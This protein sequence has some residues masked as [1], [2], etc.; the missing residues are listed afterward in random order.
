V[1]KVEKCTGVH[2]LL[3]YFL[4][5]FSHTTGFDTNL[6]QIKMY[7]IVAY[8]LKARTVEQEKQPL[9]GNARTQQ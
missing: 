2:I 3:E 1:T 5:A 4:C 8:L 9:L 6:P 7:Y